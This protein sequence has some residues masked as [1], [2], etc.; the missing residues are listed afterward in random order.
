MTTADTNDSMTDTL[1]AINIEQLTSSAMGAF[2]HN[3]IGLFGPTEQTSGTNFWLIS[4][5]NVDDVKII[6]NHPKYVRVSYSLI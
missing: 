5:K 6:L 3:T 4:S 2:G 1:S